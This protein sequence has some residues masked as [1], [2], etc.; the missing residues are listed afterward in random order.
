MEVGLVATHLLQW[1]D[2]QNNDAGAIF[3]LIPAYFE[4]QISN[5]LDYNKASFESQLAKLGLTSDWITFIYQ[6]TTK[7]DNEDKQDAFYYALQYCLHRFYV[8]YQITIDPPITSAPLNQG[9]PK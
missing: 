5:D 7:Y 6:Q 2:T 4:Y 3:D 9:Q 8:I 1:S